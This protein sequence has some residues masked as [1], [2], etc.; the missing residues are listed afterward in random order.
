MNHDAQRFEIEVLDAQQS[1]LAGSNV[2]VHRDKRP[3]A[4]SVS[5]AACDEGN[6]SGNRNQ[7]RIEDSNIGGRGIV[8]FLD[9][10][11]ECGKQSITARKATLNFARNHFRMNRQQSEGKTPLKGTASPIT[12]KT[13]VRLRPCSLNELPAVLINGWTF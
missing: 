2:L 9:L 1:D 13:L 7:F 6:A 11:D 3:A 4:N 12:G 10:I 8:T 5:I